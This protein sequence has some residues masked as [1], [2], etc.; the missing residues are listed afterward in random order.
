MSKAF[1]VYQAC[2][3]LL[4]VNHRVFGTTDAAAPDPDMVQ[5][6]TVR[7]E[8]VVH[9]LHAKSFGALYLPAWLAR[10]VIERL[11]TGFPVSFI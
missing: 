9:D 11:S 6:E 2:N 8:L 7:E 3:C 5:E 10:T 4:G 1:F